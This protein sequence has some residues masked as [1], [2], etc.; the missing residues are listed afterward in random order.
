MSAGIAVRIEAVDS[1]DDV[2][3]RNSAAIDK[4][5]ESAEAASNT[6]HAASESQPSA[7]GGNLAMRA[8]PALAAD[9][10]DYPSHGVRPVK[11]RAGTPQKLDPVA[12]DDQHVLIE[13][14]GGSLGPG[15]VTEPQAIDQQRRVVVAHPASLYRGQTPRAAVLPHAHAWHGAERFGDRI[16]RP[17][18]DLITI[19]NITRLGHFLQ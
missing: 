8:A 16:F 5:V 1:F 18:A 15:G 2:E 19:D 9:D 11:R 4:L 12:V 6:G 3:M 10:V 13:G 17:A 7:F 14:C